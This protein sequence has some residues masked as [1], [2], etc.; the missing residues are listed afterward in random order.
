MQELSNAAI[1]TLLIKPYVGVRCALT[2]RKYPYFKEH[3]RLIPQDSI[4]GLAGHGFAL[5][6]ETCSAFTPSKCTIA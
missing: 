1:C 3:Q 6:T 4:I 2:D 5:V